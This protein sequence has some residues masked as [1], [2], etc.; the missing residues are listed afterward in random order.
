MV[1]V[2]SYCDFSLNDTSNAEIHTD[3]W[4]ILLLKKIIKFSHNQ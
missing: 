1:L 3:T 2:I 4:V